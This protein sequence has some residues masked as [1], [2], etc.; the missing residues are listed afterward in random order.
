MASETALKGKVARPTHTAVHVYM[1]YS[2]RR[3]FMLQG[4]RCLVRV[5]PHQRNAQGKHSQHCSVQQ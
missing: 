5:L 4:V 3:L 2:Y 1:R